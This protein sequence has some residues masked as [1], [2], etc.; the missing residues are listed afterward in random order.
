MRAAQRPPSRRL[1]WRGL[2]GCV[3]REQ[4]R[5]LPERAWATAPNRADESP[6]LQVTRLP[7]VGGALRRAARWVGAAADQ[8]V[9][10]AQLQLR[11]ELLLLLL[12]W[13]KAFD[14]IDPV[15]MLTALDAMP[16]NPEYQA[17]VERAERAIRAE[18]RN[19]AGYTLLQERLAR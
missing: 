12:D 6:V 4:I 11:E 19:A 7:Q 9:L 17:G 18:A 15:A 14:R 2:A 5:K 3:E 8:R 16:G 10:I 13:S 1:G